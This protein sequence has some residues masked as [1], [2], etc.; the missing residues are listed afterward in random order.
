[1]I[2]GRL[3][4]IRIRIHP[5]WL[6]LFGLVALSLAQ[7]AFP[8]QVGGLSRQ[9]YW[10]MGALGALLVFASL[11]VHELAHAVV[12]RR[13]GLEVEEI[14]LFI[15]GGVARLK[16]EPPTPG[17][18][19][20]MTAVGPLSSFALSALFWWLGALAQPYSQ[21][22]AALLGY[23]ALFNFVVAVFNLLPGFPLDGG[24]LLR[25]T[26]WKITGDLVKATRAASRM[27]MLL[28]YLLVL[29][30]LLQVLSGSISGLWSVLI[31]S[32]VISAAEQS[33][34]QVLLQTSLGGVPI[35]RVMDVH[36]P[37]ASPDL[38]LREFVETFLMRSEYSVFPVLRDDRLL[39]MVGVEEVRQVAPER[40]QEVRVEQ[41]MTPVDER[42]VLSDRED[43]WTAV[44]R[45][46]A[47]D[48]RRLLVMHEGHFR[49]VVTRDAVLK[50]IQLKLQLP[51]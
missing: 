44:R 39:G 14:T 32:F 43:A 33:Y 48:V 51:V 9:A 2:L 36:P 16:S 41:V 47:S 45:M 40:W 42:R 20:K 7:G 50:L 28:G 22:A 34:Q 46:L 4:G 18:E 17:V 30:G 8:L 25:A 24:R 37:V 26:L 49:G 11:L 31:G 1:M 10:V 15:F 5:S 3:L 13:C 6:L 38:S 27:G 23:A 29:S 35:S 21:A 12:G 19:F